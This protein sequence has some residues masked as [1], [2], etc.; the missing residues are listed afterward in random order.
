MYRHGFVTFLLYIHM[1]TQ[2]MYIDKVRS[3]DWYGCTNLNNRVYIK[4]VFQKYL[5]PT[6]FCLLY[7]KKTLYQLLG[8]IFISVQCYLLTYQLDCE[9]KPHILYLIITYYLLP[10]ACMFPYEL[11]IFPRKKFAYIIPQGVNYRR[12]IFQHNISTG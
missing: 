5:R 12:A 9:G 10:M 11:Y 2:K 3:P 4:I 8:N 7:F 1:Y 6:S